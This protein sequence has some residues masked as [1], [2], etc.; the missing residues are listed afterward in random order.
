MKRRAVIV[1]MNHY[2]DKSYAALRHAEGDAVRVEHFLRKLEGALHFE[3]IALCSGR[4]DT[5]IHEAIRGAVNGLGPN[6]LF[7]FYFA[8]HGVQQ[9]GRSQHL[10]L[11]NNAIKDAIDTHNTN[12]TIPYDMLHGMTR[13]DFARVIV[14]DACRS[15]YVAGARG[16]D[17]SA[18]MR[19]SAHIRSLVEGDSLAQR[20]G[21]SVTLWSCSDGEIAEEH[22]HCGGGLFTS[23]LLAELESALEQ[24]QPA[25]MGA[26]FMMSVTARMG[27]LGDML[28][29]QQ[30][31]CSWAGDAVDL[32]AVPETF[33]GPERQPEWK[34]RVQRVGPATTRRDV[35][36]LGAGNPPQHD[37]D[38]EISYLDMPA[39]AVSPPPPERAAASE[40][41]NVV[42]SSAR[43]LFCLAALLLGAAGLEAS[44]IPLLRLAFPLLGLSLP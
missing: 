17:A 5:E 11:C 15:S 36:S 13:G 4:A 34:N 42:R 32:L 25:P 21:A 9:I 40:L 8:G 20:R 3:S 7:F 23:A 1:G 44:G 35:R 6:D 38:E 2:A 22:D 12:G 27:E 31:S 18:R 37:W 14:L 41:S 28:R 10:L 26:E 24:R 19:G 33:Y 43:V 39:V 29:L 16:D 30:P